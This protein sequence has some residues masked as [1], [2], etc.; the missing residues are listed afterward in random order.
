MLFC[1]RIK[2][3]LFDIM[4][5]YKFGEVAHNKRDKCDGKEN[6]KKNA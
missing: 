1:L 5:L 2:E 4:V 6:K 3:H